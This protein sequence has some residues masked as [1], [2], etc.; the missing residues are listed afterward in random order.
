MICHGQDQNVQ[1]PVAE[2]TDLIFRYLQN[3]PWIEVW[4]YEQVNME[5]EGCTIGFDACVNL[6]I[7]DEEVHLKQS[8]GKGDNITLLQ[9]VPK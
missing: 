6:V 5:M 4:L 8:Q 3:R 7:D 9:S 2:L 1:K